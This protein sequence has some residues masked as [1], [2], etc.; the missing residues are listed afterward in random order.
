MK[1]PISAIVVGYNEADMLKGSLSKLSFCSEI[2]YFDLGSYDNSKE[3][4]E[5]FGAQ[6]IIHEKVDGCEWI[7]AKY[8]QTT[9][10]NW[11]LITDPDEVLSNELIAE[12]TQLFQA[13][14]LTEKVGAVTAPWLFHFKNKKLL[15]TNWGGI[16]SRILLIHK[17]RFEF[18]PLVHAGRVLYSGYT[19]YDIQYNGENYIYHYWMTSY[20]K[21]FE[22][23][24]RYLKNE[25][26]AR[27]KTGRRTSVKGII[28]EPYKSFKYSYLTKHGF[29]DG[30]TGLFLSL[31]WMW[32]ECSAQVQNYR[33]QRRQ[34]KIQYQA[35]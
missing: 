28:L 27:Y 4:A 6:V 31:F 12:I 24:L 29:K 2:L 17:Q 26:E 5:S 30:F 3:I 19:K 32:Y 15:G 13:D 11:V 22:K 16:N 25:G 8:A 7:H 21:L 35:R 10:Y 14:T 1:Y 34:E 23:H 9:K 18:V 20:R 33:Y